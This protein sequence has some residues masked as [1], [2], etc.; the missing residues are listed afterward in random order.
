MVGC[1]RKA[2]KKQQFDPTIPV[3]VQVVGDS[4]E[5]DSRNYV[6]TVR[7]ERQVTLSFPLGG[8]LTAVYVHNELWPRFGRRKTATG[9]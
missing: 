9:G 2:S 4:N 1:G 8:T 3:T 5:V 6:G 7:S